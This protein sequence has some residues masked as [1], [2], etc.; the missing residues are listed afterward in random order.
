[1]EL[2]VES[3]DIPTGCYVGVRVGD[4][5]K[6]GRYEPSRCYHFP[7]VDRRRNARIDIYQHVGSAVVAVDPDTK[8][9]H[10]VKV[11]NI[12]LTSPPMTLQ[13][14]VQ[15]K[16]SDAAKE[17]REQRTKALKTQAKDY[18]S[19]HSIEER[20]SEAVK[21]LLKE[22]PA[23]P[24]EFLCRQLRGDIGG[25]KPGLAPVPEPAA[26]VKQEVT[27]PKK[28]VAAPA[29]Q[30]A[31]PAAAAPAPKPAPMQTPAPAPA[32]TKD[33]TALRQQA[34]D[35]LMKAS[36]DG[37]LANVLA[38]VKSESAL[39]SARGADAKGDPQIVLDPALKFASPPAM[40]M[41]TIS[42]LGGRA[43]DLGMS[44][45]LLFI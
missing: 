12:D 44:P 1:M 37:N 38:E 24:T 30:Q 19:Q 5:L 45:G 15:S 36:N 29:P 40:V 41:N 6:Q 20:L 28:E 42:L 22:Q 32:G 33:L 35:V 7:Q 43:V 26:A 2:R 17:N 39:A 8:S 18:L 23:D 34:C 31:K 9:S 3:A 14:N 27:A 25:A 16:A 4:V 11:Q 21:A 10:E 13:V